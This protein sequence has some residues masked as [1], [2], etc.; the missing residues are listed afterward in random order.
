M[1]IHLFDFDNV[2]LS[3]GK[4]VHNTIFLLPAFHLFIHYS[5]STTMLTLQILRDNA[6]PF[7][8]HLFDF[9]LLSVLLPIHASFIPTR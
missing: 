4:K 3:T 1:D 8:L 9:P 7:S 2:G 5:G 6:V